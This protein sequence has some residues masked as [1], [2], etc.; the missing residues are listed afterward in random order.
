MSRY[1]IQRARQVAP[2]PADAQFLHPAKP[3]QQPTPRSTPSPHRPSPQLSLTPRKSKLAGRIDDDGN[4]IPPEVTSSPGVPRVQTRGGGGGGT[5]GGA[6]GVPEGQLG[7]PPLAGRHVDVEP[8]HLSDAPAPPPGKVKS[9]KGGAR[10]VSAKKEKY[11]TL[12]EE[13]STVD[14]LSGL[15]A[16]LGEA[17]LTMDAHRSTPTKACM[18]LLKLIQ[19]RLV[20][21]HEFPVADDSQV[22]FSATLT[23]AVVNPV[24]ELAAQVEVQ[25]RAIQNMSKK[26]ESTYNAPILT[27]PATPTGSYAEATSKPKPT[28]RLMEPP[29]PRGSG[30]RILVRFTGPPPPLFT[31]RYDEIVKGLNAHLA[32][33]GLPAILFVQKQASESP[34]YFIAPCLGREGVAILEERWDEWAPGIIPGGRIVPVVAHCFVQVDGVAFASVESYESV[35][36][37]FEELNPTLGKVVGLP[38][39]KNA[40]PSEARIAAAR[41]DGRRIPVAGSLIFKLESKDAV[42]RTVVS[43]RVY[44]AGHAPRVGRVFP[45]LDV[46]QCWGCYK[47]GH[48][49]A[50]C[51][52]PAAKCGGCGKA[53]HGIICSETP[54]CINCS[55]AHRADNPVCPVRKEHA[56]KQRRRAAELCRVLDQQSR[57]TPHYESNTT[58]TS[59]LSPLSPTLNLPD[60]F[61]VSPTLAPWL[62]ERL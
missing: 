35:A 18:A 4:V 46:V 19:E 30:E 33:L 15:G 36:R 14:S 48:I 3:S 41:R 26:L 6:H 10:K 29:L 57:Y 34:G 50:R 28:P 40:P 5:R 38:R 47:H 54:V 58:A 44:L 22:S 13:A 1:A 42:D 32:S 51:N 31:L 52:A 43:G 20:N 37:Q 59:P 55:G 49:R 39:F 9:A 61:A 27:P 24:K 56:E 8:N 11:E 12:H 2:L 23:R 21:H 53:P 17:I 16:I 45:H 60:A 62:H 25:Q 7:L